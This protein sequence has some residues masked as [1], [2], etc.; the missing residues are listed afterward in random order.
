[1]ATMRAFRAGI[2]WSAS[3]HS[4]AILDSHDSPRFRVVAGSRERQLVGVGLQ[5]TTPGVPMVFAGSEIG[6]AGDWG[7]DARRPMPW[8]RPETWDTEA[9][10]GHRGLRGLRGCGQTPDD[11]VGPGTQGGL[12][13]VPVHVP[14]DRVELGRPGGGM[15][16][17]EGLCAACARMASPCGNSTRAA[18][19]PSHRTAR[20]S[21]DG[22]SRM[23]CATR[24]PKV[25][26]HREH[27]NERTWV[28]Y[29]QA[30]PLVRVV[31][32]VGDAG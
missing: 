22:G 20:Q 21:A 4:W 7:E 23:A 6:L 17:T 29:H 3:L 10:E 26:D 19:A 14:K 32:H 24:L 2:P 18:R 5:M 9:L 31:A 25:R 13:R 30:P 28:C 8:S 12:E 27:F 11:T 16:E 1:M 15:G